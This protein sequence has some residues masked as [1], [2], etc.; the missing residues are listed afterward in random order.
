MCLKECEIWNHTLPNVK[1]HSGVTPYTVTT[2][3][4]KILSQL[5]TFLPSLHFDLFAFT[6]WNSL[7]ILGFFLDVF[8]KI[9]SAFWT[10]KLRTSL[11]INILLLNKIKHVVT[12]RKCILWKICRYT[13]VFEWELS[14]YCYNEVHFCTWMFRY[15]Y[16]TIIVQLK[17]YSFVLLHRS[18][19]VVPLLYF[20]VIVL[21]LYIFCTFIFQYFCCT[22]S[23]LFNVLFWYVFCTTQK[24]YKIV[25]QNKVQQLYFQIVVL[26]L[27]FMTAVPRK[28]PFK[29][30]CVLVQFQCHS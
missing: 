22:F 14:G 2:S 4:D 25:L 18:T 23:V 17:E 10:L 8:L 1:R 24:K 3:T 21:S 7:T 29:N 16:S 13:A 28:Y 20:R 30:G 5:I 6:F 15:F 19:F 9:V 27:Y 11:D 12:L 26:F